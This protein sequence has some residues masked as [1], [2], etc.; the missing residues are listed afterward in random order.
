MEAQLDEHDKYQAEDQQDG[1]PRARTADTIWAMETKGD[2]KKETAIEELNTEVDKAM[3]G[4]WCN[5]DGHRM[6]IAFVKGTGKMVDRLYRIKN[7]A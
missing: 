4:G 7:K 2:G 1:L 5:A 6:E 3:G